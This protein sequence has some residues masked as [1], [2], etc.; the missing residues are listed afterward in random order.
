M[1]EE[2]VEDVEQDVSVFWDFGSMQDRA[3]AKRIGPRVRDEWQNSQ[4]AESNW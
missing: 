1:T 4:L 3:K 2:N